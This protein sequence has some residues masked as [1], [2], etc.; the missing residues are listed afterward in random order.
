MNDEFWE[1]ILLIF[2][3]GKK[4]GCKGGEQEYKS[5]CAHVQE[6]SVTNTAVDDL[7]YNYDA[8]G[9]LDYMRNLLVLP[10]VVCSFTA[11]CVIT[12]SCF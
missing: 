9:M 12:H 7:L 2:W 1:D 4:A 5:A 6:P 8:G 3:P 10:G 11:L